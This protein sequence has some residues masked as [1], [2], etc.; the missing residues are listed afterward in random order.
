[1]PARTPKETVLTRN[2]R[3]SLHGE[4]IPAPKLLHG[5][6]AVLDVLGLRE[7][8]TPE[9]LQ[10]VYYHTVGEKGYLSNRERSMIIDLSGKGRSR[11]GPL[12]PQT[13]THPFQ[14]SLVVFSTGSPPY[15]RLVE[16]LV[17]R[18]MDPFRDAL[19]DG[20]LFRGVISV[21][22]FYYLH[23]IVAG[24]AF[25]EAIAWHDRPDWA[26]I[27]LTPSALYAYQTA[28]HQNSGRW[29]VV[30][31]TVPLKDGGEHR[32]LVLNWPMRFDREELVDIFSEMTIRPDTEA[33][34]RNTL[35]FYDWSRNER[36]KRARRPLP[37]VAMPVP[38]S[39]VDQRLAKPA[40]AASRTRSSGRRRNDSTPKRA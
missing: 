4:G 13:K 15:H 3:I 26:G 34:Y 30:P 22:S 39:A 2:R 36:A 10:L 40:R 6:V 29:P 11:R 35:A 16:H 38:P 37:R 12:P 20:V 18:L 8:T 23:P 5:A 17:D 28:V 33:K 27:S 1:M 32:T 14:D 31:Y 19:M 24:P 21:G 7:Q 25:Y 9:F